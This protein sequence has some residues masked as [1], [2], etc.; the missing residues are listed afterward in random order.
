MSAA[1][2]V[3]TRAA[4]I[5][6]E[7]VAARSARPSAAI[8]G[9]ARALDEPRALDERIGSTDPAVV[10][11]QQEEAVSSDHLG[12]RP[13]SATASKT[14]LLKLTWVPTSPE[15]HRERSTTS[16]DTPNQHNDISKASAASSSSVEIPLASP[17]D[18]TSSG[19]VHATAAPL[20]E[21]STDREPVAGPSS[22]K[23]VYAELERAPVAERLADAAQS[24]DAT[25][26]SVEK[27]TIE[28]I[29]TGTP[30]QEVEPAVV[31]GAGSSISPQDEEI[32]VLLRA[33]TVP[34]SRLGRL[35]HYGS[36][37]AS[38]GWGAASESIRRTTGGGS[39]GSVFMS[40]ANV[41][42]LV[43]S[44][45]RMRG[46]ALKLG[47]FMSI[48]DNQM[49]PPEIEKVL[50]QVQ[51]HANYMPDWQMEKVMSQELGSDWQSLFTEFERTPIASAS[52]GQVHRATL[53][54]DGS[55]VAVKI[56]FPGIANSI[57]SDLSYLTP[58]LRSSAVLPKGLYLQNT[59]AVMRRELADECDYKREADA[60][61][62]F[63][64]FL[65]GDEFFDVPK[66]FPEATTDKILTTEWIAGKPLSK[67]T[68]MSQETRDKI[69][70]NVLRLCLLELFHFRF[71]QTDPN[72]ANFLYD[73]VRGRLGL[74]DFGASREYTKEFMDGW[75]RLL[76]AALRGDR[77]VMREASEEIGYLTG[78]ENDMMLQAHLDSM[79]LVASPFAHSGP[80]DF[81]S[82][83]ITESVRALIPVMLQHRLTPPPPETYSLN[84]K[85]SGAF[86]MCARLGAKVDCGKLWEE[87]VAG[88]EVDP[89]N[90]ETAQPVTASA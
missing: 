30:A 61:Q 25:P 41:R 42:R 20:H 85:L 15:T 69:G 24:L 54:S 55:P 59:I 50:Q 66:V 83:T 23:T 45:T 48:Q 31:S 51:A 47:Q 7:E 77:E 26:S 22:S 78:E 72:W 63:R 35:F 75:F 79:A 39:Q 80:Y 10:G 4:V 3:L 18:T 34:S 2:R 86:L 68:G 71:M 9:K 62:R 27:P 8:K 84:R 16:A 88:Y 60:G 1:I 64:D 53:A 82:Q 37:A 89:Q 21:L 28:P 90:M 70:T 19:P 29:A 49:L 43:A 12:P 17:S 67:M 56:Q 11:V 38:L 58:L 81:S 33:A 46:A 36:L 44:L 87:Y 40:D 32:P 13:P 5:Q 6:L 57:S 76:S 65:E 74:I 73:P 14:P 52:I